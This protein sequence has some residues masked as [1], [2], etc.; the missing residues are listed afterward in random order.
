MNKNI[1]EFLSDLADLGVK[2]RI[3][4]DRLRCKIPEDLRSSDIKQELIERKQEVINFISN[5]NV[6]TI[7][8]DKNSIHPVER[9]GKLPLSFAQQRLWFL[10]QLESDSPFYNLPAAVR[11]EGK[12]DLEALQQSFNKIITRHEALR[13]NFQ[14]TEEGEAL[15]I[16][17]QVEFPTIPLLD[18]SDLSTS[19]KQTQIQQQIETE[20]QRPFDI[21]Y[22]QLIRIKLLHLEE[23]EHIVLL[24]MHHIISDGWSVGVLVEELATLYQAFSQGKPSPLAEL[25]I[26]YVDFVAWQRQWLQGEVLETQQ[27]Y[28]LKQLENVPILELPTDHPR[29]ATQ[30]FRGANYSFKLSKE[31]SAAL[32]RLSQQQGVTLF[33]TLLAGFQTLLWR[34]TAQDDIIVGSPIANRNRGEI[35]GLIGLF[36]NTLVLKTNLEGNPS[37]AELLQR[38]KETALGA[39]AHQ[40]LP[41]ELLVEQLQPERDLSYSPLFQ[42]MFALQNAPMSVLELP[43]LTLTSIK[44]DSGTSQFDLTLSMMETESGL[45]G[46]FEYNTDLFKPATILRMVGHLKTLLAAIVANPQQRLSQLPLLTKPEQQQLL[47]EWNDTKVDYSQDQ[48]IHQL[49]EAQVE[50]TPD[51]MAVVFEDEQLTYQELNVKSNQLAHY[52]QTLGV[53]P[54][55][56]VAICVDRSLEMVIGL[57]AILKAGGAYIPLDPNYP[58]ER[59][60]FILEQTKASVLLTQATLREEIP[61]HQARV[62]CLD[63]EWDSIAQQ[64][65]ENLS[66]LVTSD[67]LAYIIYT[68]G[69][70]GKPK[71]VQI[72]HLA[73]SNFL[74]SMRETPGLSCED[75]LLAVTTYSFDISAL[76]LFLPL[77]VGARLIVASQ[78]VISDGT[79]LSTKLVKSKATVMQATPVTWQL[80]LAAGWN[81][82]PQL[83]VL[84]GGEVLPAPL[85]TQLIARCD[86]LWNMYGPTETTIWSA[87][88]QV[89]AVN[90]TVPIS[91]PIANTQLY[92]LDQHNQ[93]VPV[94]VAGELCIA[95]IGLSRGYFHRPDLT[96][97]KFIPN[98]IPLQSPLS[99]G[100]WGNRLYKTGDLA[101]YQA[102][103]EI[104]YLGRIDNQVKIRGF[105]IE[106]GEIEAQL[107]KYSAVRD[108][109]VIS[110][111][112]S[113]GSKRLVAYYISQEQLDS[114]QLREYLKLKL[115]DYMIPSA[116]LQLDVFPLT[117]NG[118]VDRKALPIPDLTLTTNNY[119]AP[120]TIREAKIA[121]I[122]QEVLNVEQVG[123]NDNF[124]E[125]GGHSLLATKVIS[126]IRQSLSVEFPLRSLFEY[127]TIGELAERLAQIDEILE[128]PPLKSVSKEGDIPLS[129]AQKRLWF[130]SQLEPESPAYNIP[131]TLHL[132]G[133][134]DL[135]VLTQTLKAIIERH[136]TLRTTFS[137]V[138]QEPVQ[139]IHSQVDLELPLIDLTNLAKIERER[140]ASKLAEEES[141]KSFD[142]E[143]D[144]LLRVSLIKLN[145]LEHIILLT[146]H[147]IVSDDWSTGI[148]I[149]EFASLYRAFVEGKSSPLPEL[150]IQYSDF[151][152]WQR[153]YL[154][155]EILQK[156]KDYW[157]DQLENAPQ[158]LEL[159]TDYPRPAIQTFRGANYTFELDQ[160]LSIAL[161]LLSQKRGSTLYM[162]LLTVFGI[163]LW[164]YTG[165]ED[166]LVGSPIA[167][168]S[169]RE[170][171]GLIGFFINTLAL[172]I[173][174]TG[175]SSFET[176]LKQ[177]RETALAGYA[178]QDLPFELLVEQLQLERDLSYTPIFQVMFALQN[179]PMSTLELPGLTLTSVDSEIET[180][181]FDLTLHMA[182]TESGLEGSF[183]YNTDLFKAATIARMV[184]HFKILL[185]AIVVNPQQQL[186]T[187]P[188]LTESEQ[189]QLLVSWNDT[190]RN[191]PQQ[192]IHTLFE[193][194]VEKTPH[195]V[196]VVFKNQQ[197]T[198]QELNHRANQLA[199]Y[200]QTLGIKSEALVGIC[201]ER[202]LEM[203]VGL[204]AILKANGA[205]VPLD[206]SYPL[207]RLAY[208]LDNSQ[209]SVLLTQTSLVGEIPQHQAQVV[210]L[211]TDRHLISQQSQENLSSKVTLDNL[212]YVIYTSGSTGKPKGVQIPHLALSNF[213]H[214]MREAP[215][216]S[217]RDTLLAVTTYSFDI[218]ALELFLPL[219]SGA[220]LVVVGQ[221][222]VSD[223]VELSAILDSQATVMQ[224]T[225]ATWQLL[226]AAGW[227]GNPQ[228]KILCGGEALPPQLANQL[229]Q[230]CNSLWNMYGPT[231]TT[232]WSAVSQVKKVDDTVPIS[233]PVANTQLYILD[234]YHQLVPIGVVGELCI[235][236]EGLARG[237]F[238]RPDL[239]AEKF[240]PNP[241]PP[242]SRLSKGGWG[243][244]LYKTGD[245]ARYLPT[246]EIEYMGR[247]DHQVK[248]RGFRI[249]L[250][251]IETA[252]AQHPAVQE[253]VVV[254]REES[255][256][257]KSLVAYAIAQPEPPLTISALREFLTSKLPKYMIPSALVILETLPLT[258]NGKVDRKALAVL[259]GTRAK[260]DSITVPRNFIECQLAEIWAEVLNVDQ[261]GIFDNFF[262][263]GGDSIL[264][265]VAI[266]KANQAGAFKLTV[267]QLFQHQTIANLATVAVT[268]KIE[269]AKPQVDRQNLATNY[270]KANL[271][272]QELERF[273]TKVT[274][275]SENKAI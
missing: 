59:T 56:K 182:E 64:S 13:T 16:I 91:C 126:K 87:A 20:A 275:G 114:K 44:S 133:Q 138:G 25:P 128:I 227:N 180:A 189:Q 5:N 258:P 187:L 169:R 67:N 58:Q 75:T 26:Q 101:R 113:Q 37:F 150:S 162:T 120:T 98:P 170:L 134:L 200:L 209:A 213:L 196:A 241:I 249:E 168:R 164:R 36:A 109:V 49:F 95:G 51:A 68:S 105:R 99:K 72:S 175:N 172:R 157:L 93:L 197:L 221:E 50:K 123:I 204:L 78:E 253:T 117:P 135:E 62:V 124:F 171:E 217:D 111:E 184:E 156:Q 137:M 257:S 235:A 145:E 55:V 21:S 141:L 142:L 230:R 225:P 151:A 8:T 192:C 250:G 30:T 188:L 210:Y 228:L 9:Q 125:L 110:G 7:A 270:S 90:T 127:P 69:S 79:Q 3:E 185:K 193:V 218:A 15:A 265:T 100:G 181:K 240:I 65:Q 167:N 243:N 81:G 261:V 139:V 254:A 146:T 236:G 52:L 122:W 103:G 17:S 140:E 158:V 273:L 246:G 211:D 83:K 54:E 266:A 219:I 39:Y 104:E 174:L 129:F 206:P 160:E 224:A 19:Q 112:N 186:S 159:P 116:W 115:P 85:A 57:L 96:A 35:E 238:Q 231:E 198:Y 274:R 248:L 205:Y 148:L 42:V 245:L 86:S 29:P 6:A 132:Q 28:W 32:D 61:P 118:K 102:N 107:R 149:Q 23:K 216:L 212:A 130:L 106:L 94:G 195:A 80:L 144:S 2:L 77:I 242:Q 11:L 179:P 190:A 12:L 233:C 60:A 34:Y 163:L 108:C 272:P 92:I 260:L 199:H 208:I 269:Q 220:R 229:L 155:G 252:I 262:D 121:E 89:K 84:C 152:V 66:N 264:A 53:K 1:E 251:E 234:R 48:C 27:A 33:M 165:Q 177:V 14:T 271:N 143:R 173:N 4:G 161:N 214:S 18:L 226:L 194:Q 244:R 97:E 40:D 147:H 256:D 166:I 176:L 232:I 153:K 38:V 88:S 223:G 22:E 207:E 154:Q 247:I 45:E 119:I 215:G 41:F 263:L 31:L 255:T 237:Y 136:E 239:T 70:T 47:V 183:E 74:S 82:N 259:P 222:V 131:E 203:V 46:S 202:S 73:L 191:Y 201:V 24:T 76:E 267:K 63:A 71:G 268:E 43:D 10:T 178:H